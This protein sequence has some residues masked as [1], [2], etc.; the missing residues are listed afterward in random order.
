MDRPTKR[1]EEVKIGKFL[2]VD[3]SGGNGGWAR[4]CSGAGW[5]LLRGRGKRAL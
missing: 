2:E 5:A 4:D 3:R 1:E